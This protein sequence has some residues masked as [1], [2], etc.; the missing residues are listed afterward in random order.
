MSSF[1]YKQYKDAA[2]KHLKSCQQIIKYFNCQYNCISPSI[3]KELLINVFY[4]SGY[5]MECII[6]YAIFRKIYTSNKS[7]SKSDDVYK[8]VDTTNKF[9]FYSKYKDNNGVTYIARYYVSG[10]NFMNNITL[11]KK[12]TPGSNIPLVHDP[13][14]V[15]SSVNTLIRK[16][17]VKIRYE[18]NINP[19]INKTDIANL[20]E[21]TEK[22]YNEVI[23]VVR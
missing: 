23:K 21:F 13:K 15:P 17:N 11:L 3:E 8:I 19:P 22:F 5:T 18:T 10:H 20:V 6:N 16:W 12:L 2:L 1:C 9:S 14:I 4:L 7:T